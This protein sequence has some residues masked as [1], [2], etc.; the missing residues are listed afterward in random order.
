MGPKKPVQ[1]RFIKFAGQKGFTVPA[2]DVNNPAKLKDIN[3]YKKILTNS[4]L[5]EIVE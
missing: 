5:F 3:I 2:V 4:M 1:K